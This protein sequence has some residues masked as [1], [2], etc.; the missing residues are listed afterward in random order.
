VAEHQSGRRD[1]AQR[2]W[3]LVN[4]EMWMRRAIEGDPLTGS[5]ALAG[6]PA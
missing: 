1:H 5:A 6:A 4:L 2:L 3:S